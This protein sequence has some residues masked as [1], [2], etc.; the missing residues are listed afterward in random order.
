M[1]SDC[2]EAPVTAEPDPDGIAVCSKCGETCVVMDFEKT[3]SPDRFGF[4]DD[5]NVAGGIFS[6]AALTGILIVA[7]GFPWMS[8]PWVG[9][10]LTAVV[11]CGLGAY[12]TRRAE[13]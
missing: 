9:G 7:I 11:I 6:G 3:S 4:G 1:N 12:R 13:G 8:G 2:C 10:I 5:G